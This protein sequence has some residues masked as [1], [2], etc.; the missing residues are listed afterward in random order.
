M[1]F[2]LSPQFAIAGAACLL[3]G[4]LS[5]PAAVVVWNGSISDDWSTA[6]NWSPSGVP[7]SSDQA[8]INNGD[9][10]NQNGSITLNDVNGTSDDGLQLTSGTLYVTGDFTSF[11]SGGSNSSPINNVGVDGGA[12]TASLTVD[13]T[14][15]IGN[16]KNTSGSAS[17][18]N[19]FSGSSVVTNIF[20]GRHAGS[21]SSDNTGGWNL[22]VTGGSMFASTFSWSTVAASDPDPRGVITLG[23]T[24]SAEGGSLTVT[25]MSADWDDRSNQYVLFNDELGSLTFGKTNYENI[26]DVENLLFNDFIRKDASITNPFEVTDNGDSWTVSIV[27]EPSTYALIF[28][29]LVLPLLA[30]RRR[31]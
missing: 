16:T 20:Q 21:S 30:L 7:G 10:V 8:V 29:G 9:S 26:A 6:D 5:A 22:N 4:T 11:T 2:T 19:I 25:T 18:L 15:S 27:P 23:S 1:K 28:G 24:S 13:G 31:R 17:S 14:L 12:T 3:I